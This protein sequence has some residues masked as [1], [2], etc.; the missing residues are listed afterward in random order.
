MVQFEVCSRFWLRCYSTP[1]RGKPEANTVYTRDPNMQRQPEQ[2]SVSIICPTKDAFLLWSGPT[3]LVG[4]ESKINLEL[5]FDIAFLLA[6]KEDGRRWARTSFSK[7]LLKIACVIWIKHPAL[8]SYL[9]WTISLKQI[10]LRNYVLICRNKSPQKNGKKKAIV[11]M[12][13]GGLPCYPVNFKG[14]PINSSAEKASRMQAS[15]YGW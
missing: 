2:I 5:R 8:P 13:S 4:K 6:A 15:V 10:N 7:T 12:V 9:S 1:I 3:R 11:N 14:V